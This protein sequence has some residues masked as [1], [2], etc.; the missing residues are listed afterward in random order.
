MRCLSLQFLLG[1]GCWQLE[2]APLLGD[3]FFPDAAG[4]VARAGTQLIEP[5]WF[6]P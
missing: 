4:G 5:I 3:Y 1:F 6:G 2:I